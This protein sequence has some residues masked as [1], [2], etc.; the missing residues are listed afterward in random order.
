MTLHQLKGS[1]AS[2]SE[3]VDL[4]FPPTLCVTGELQIGG[5]HSP[6]EEACLQ[7]FVFWTDS[8]LVGYT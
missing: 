8:Y 1:A 2:S 6:R 7:Q 5:C 3:L 4:S